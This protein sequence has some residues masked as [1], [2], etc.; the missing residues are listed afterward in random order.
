MLLSSVPLQEKGQRHFREQG[1]AQDV[2]HAGIGEAFV[3]QGLLGFFQFR[4]QVIGRTMSNDR[5]IA[6]AHLSEFFVDGT[7]HT[8]IFAANDVA[9]FIGHD[10]ITAI[11]DV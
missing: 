6:D 2:F 9:H 1:I 11:E 5:F 7:G 4:C 10:L 3:G 8:A